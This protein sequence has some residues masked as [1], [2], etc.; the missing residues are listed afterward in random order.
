MNHRRFSRGVSLQRL[1]DRGDPFGYRLSVE[2]ELGKITVVVRLF[3]AR[4]TGSRA[5]GLEEPRLLDH[6][7]PE[8][9]HSACRAISNSIARPRSDG[10]HVDRRGCRTDPT[11]T[12][13]RDVGVA[14]ELPSSMFASLISVAG[15]PHLGQIRHRLGRRPQIGFETI[16]SSGTPARVPFDERDRVGHVGT[17]CRGAT[18]PH[19]PRDGPAPGGFRA[20]LSV[21]ISREPPR[22]IERSNCVIWY[23]FGEVGIEVRSCAQPRARVDL[24]ADREAEPDRERHG[25]PVDDRQRAGKPEADGTGRRSSAPPRVIRRGQ[26]ILDSVSSWACTS[27]PITEKTFTFPRG[28]LQNFSTRTRYLRAMTLWERAGALLAAFSRRGSRAA[29]DSVGDGAPWPPAGGIPR[30]GRAP[31]RARH[32]GARTARL[33]VRDAIRRG[34]PRSRARATSSSRRGPASRSRCRRPTASRSSSSR[35]RAWPP[36]TQDGEEPWRE[37]HRQ[38]C[39]LSARNREPRP[40]ACMPSSDR[41]SASVAT[42]SAARWRR[43]SRATSCAAGAGGNSGSI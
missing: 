31:D 2:V 43:V 24:A 39:G 37:R 9:T 17:G 4:M 20:P 41:P 14:P 34:R 16:S 40:A 38:G 21:E 23:P 19:L 26:N 11:R 3:L 32:A 25:F 12:A 33:A 30:P 7:L 15:A 28:T 36:F 13:A 42:K 8:A 29:G 5:R 18:C 35:T 27:S 1:A 6:G 22:T 10:F